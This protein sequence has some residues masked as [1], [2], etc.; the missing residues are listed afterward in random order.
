[1]RLKYRKHPRKKPVTYKKSLIR[2]RLAVLPSRC[3]RHSDNLSVR[4]IRCCYHCTYKPAYKRLRYRKHLHIEIARYKTSRIYLNRST[5][6]Q[7]KCRCRILSRICSD[8]HNWC[9]C[10]RTYKPVG[11]CRCRRRSGNLIARY[12]LTLSSHCKSADLPRMKPTFRNR[13][14]NH[15]D[16]YIPYYYRRIYT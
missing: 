1:M 7:C 6:L 14:C 3:R 10:P 15:F 13:L 8:R 9:C 12:K 16:C 2:C 5:A 11:K 4:H